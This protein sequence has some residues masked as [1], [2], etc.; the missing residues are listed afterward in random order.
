MILEAER[1][2]KGVDIESVLGKPGN[3]GTH[4]FA[5]Q[6]EHQ[7]VIVQHLLA[8]ARDQRYPAPRGIDGFDLAEAMADTNRIEQLGKRKC[9]LAEIDLVIADADV[10]IGI[11]V[12]DVDLDVTG[13]GADLVALACGTDGRP[14]ACKP[15]AE[16]DDTRHVCL[17]RYPEETSGLPRAGRLAHLP[18]STNSDHT[19]P[20]HKIAA[21]ASRSSD[22]VAPKRLRKAR[23]K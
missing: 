12:D 21:Q 1:R 14:Q 6:R 11:A 9:D 2:R 3:V 8:A 23:L 5:A 22:G 4:D 17:L 20:M 16:H 19:A 13:A 7:A 10:V 18:G 15:G